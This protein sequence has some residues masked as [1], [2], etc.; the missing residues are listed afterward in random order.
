MD[1]WTIFRYNVENFIPRFFTALVIFVVS[2]YLSKIVSKIA[3]KLLDARQPTPNAAKL[4]ED[5]VRWGILTLG[6]IMS[7]QQFVD[8]TAFLAG[9][10]ILGFTV[11][12]ALQ[13]VMKNF[14]A[15]VILLVQHPF[16][17]GDAIL[18][19]EF[20]G[21]VRAIDLRS[22]EMLTHDGRVVILPNSEV[23]NH[24]IINY[25]R[26]TERRIDVQVGVAYGSDLALARQAALDAVESLSY[27]LQNPA[28]AVAFH[29]FNASS[30]D[31]LVQFWVNTGQV[32]M[33]VARNDA[34]EAVAAAFAAKGIEIPF[35]VQRVIQG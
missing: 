11:G 25:T 4:I 2:F 7:I 26:S 1:L 12:F 8:V 22:T 5:V 10:G 16:R 29:L 21:T 30:I 13:D 23:L 34:L 17:V 20:E 28:P 27:I 31:L 6:V 19:Q 18:V 24:P 3:R 14:A 32:S 15:G 9:L 35:P 33:S